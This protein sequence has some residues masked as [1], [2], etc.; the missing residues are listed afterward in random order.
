M[1]VNHEKEFLKSI[2]TEALFSQL[3]ARVQTAPISLIVK[4]N[5][6]NLLQGVLRTCYLLISGLI[7]DSL[8]MGMIYIS[9]LHIEDIYLASISY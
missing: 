7:A 2:H 3:F 8:K 1:P 5:V 9:T 4:I 6:P